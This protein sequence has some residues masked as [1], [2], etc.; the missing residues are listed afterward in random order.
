M[1]WII[2]M[3][4]CGALGGYA[5][6]KLKG[7]QKEGTLLG[8]FLG[9]LGLLILLALGDVRPKCHQC[10]TVYERGARICPRCQARLPVVAVARD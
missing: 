5:G 9:P 6:E 4:A 10:R 7:R 8:L 3:I 2:W 1:T